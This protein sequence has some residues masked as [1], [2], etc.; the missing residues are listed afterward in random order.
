[1]ADS[2]KIAKPINVWA[3]GQGNHKTIFHGP[4]HDRCLIRFPAAAANVAQKRE[5]ATG[6]V[7]KVAQEWIDEMLDKGSQALIVFAHVLICCL[8]RSH[9]GSA[10]PLLH[11]RSRHSGASDEIPLYV[12]Y[13]TDRLIKS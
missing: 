2:L 10:A 8:S 3:I 5:R 9:D 12:G 7:G 6:S 1:M 13:L 11:S 4:D